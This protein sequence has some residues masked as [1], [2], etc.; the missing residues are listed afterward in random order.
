LAR[1]LRLPNEEFIQLFPKLQDESF[2]RLAPYA[3][4]MNKRRQVP[5]PEGGNQVINL[6]AGKDGHGQLRPDA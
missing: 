4:N 5:V 1:C 6:Q 3:R 2:G